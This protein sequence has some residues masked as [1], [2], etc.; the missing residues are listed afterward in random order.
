MR[1][2]RFLALF[3][4]MFVTLGVTMWRKCDECKIYLNKKINNVTRTS[5]IISETPQNS[6]RMQNTDLIQ[7]ISRLKQKTN[8]SFN[9][10][11]NVFIASLNIFKHT[12]LPWFAK[13]VWFPRYVFNYSIRIDTM[14]R[15]SRRQWEKINQ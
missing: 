4:W 5:N 8:Y 1:K 3:K 12:S 13:T 9:A 7:C 11:L 14:H 10:S 15:F 6:K 2:K